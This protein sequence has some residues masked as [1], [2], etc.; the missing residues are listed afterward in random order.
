MVAKQCGGKYDVICS[1]VFANLCGDYSQKNDSIINNTNSIIKH[2]ISV[3][4]V[5]IGF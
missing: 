3:I 2:P 1:H 4:S 5:I